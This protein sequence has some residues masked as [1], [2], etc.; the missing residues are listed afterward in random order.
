[1]ATAQAVGNGAI[2]LAVR[3]PWPNPFEREASLSF[4][5]PKA[6]EVRVTITDIHG[7]RVRRLVS[8]SLPAGEHA[9]RW[10]G[11]DERG[12]DVATGIYFVTLE[13]GAAVVR[14]RVALLR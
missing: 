4:S 2:R 10:D 3:R 14:T 12:R 5:L 6:S 11:R 13:A 9:A 8:G 1:M 7:R